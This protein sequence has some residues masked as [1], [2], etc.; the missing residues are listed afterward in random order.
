M[1]KYCLTFLL[2][3]ISNAAPG[4]ALCSTLATDVLCKASGY[5]LWTTTCV[6]LTMPTDCYKV[7]EIGACRAGGVYIS[8]CYAISALNVQYE[9]VCTPNSN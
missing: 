8:N 4:Q 9:N 2:F 5:C 7:N 6:A 1:Y 3:W